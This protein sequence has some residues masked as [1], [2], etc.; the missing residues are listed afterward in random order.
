[1]S[2]VK[3]EPVVKLGALIGE[4]PVWEE[5][6]Q[7]LLFVDIASHKIHRWSQTTNQ[8]ESVDTGQ[9][10]RMKFSD[11]FP[12]LSFICLYLSISPVR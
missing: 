1:M 6:D 12:T 10:V 4:G 5:S 8:I 11:F 2:S 9:P 3:V 7:S